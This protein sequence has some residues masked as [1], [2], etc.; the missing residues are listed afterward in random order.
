M[1]ATALPD[2]LQKSENYTGIVIAQRVEIDTTI[3]VGGDVLE[4]IAGKTFYMTQEQ[5]TVFHSML[6]YHATCET[7][8]SDGMA[9]FYGVYHIS[10]NEFFRVTQDGPS[11][12]WCMCIVSNIFIQLEPAN[13][14]LYGFIADLNSVMESS[15][16]VVVPAD[17]NNSV[18]FTWAF[19]LM[20]SSDIP[21]FIKQNVKGDLTRTA[22]VMLCA[23]SR[24]IDC[25][26]D[27]EKSTLADTLGFSTLASVSEDVIFKVIQKPSGA[28]GG[29]LLKAVRY[30]NDLWTVG[31]PGV[32]KLTGVRYILLRCPEIESHMFSSFAYGRFCP[33]I[34][35]FKLSTNQET[36]QQRLDF[37]NFVKKPF[38]PIG[39]LKKITFRFE[40]PNGALYDFRGVD[41]FMLMQVK[42]YAPRASIDIPST[43]NPEYDPDYTR[44]MVRQLRERAA[45]LSGED[46]NDFNAN[47][48]LREQDRYD[49][50]SEDE[51]GDEPY[52]EE[53]DITKNFQAGA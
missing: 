50:S 43:L 33:G 42:Y 10:P 24:N 2:G 37:V 12:N 35:L 48:V 41:M 47:D 25:M 31:A 4:V 27:Y 21:Q 5:G 38:H 28:G 15:R 23:S 7:I 32:I 17:E 9:V 16:N 11:K 30:N 45:F 39:R 19:P 3:F 36:V 18:E 46:T 1:F 40:L 6:P 49:F 8:T 53:I 22:R 44:Y 13:Y 20:S 52:E 29:R 26:I 14:D 34:G 51:Y